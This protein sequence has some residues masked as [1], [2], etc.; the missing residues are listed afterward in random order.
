MRIPGL[1]FLIRIFP[2]VLVIVIIAIVLYVI[3]R[4]W[5]KNVAILAIARYK[6]WREERKLQKNI[7]EVLRNRRR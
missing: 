1:S 5:L 4:L 2:S 3:W 7:D 6:A